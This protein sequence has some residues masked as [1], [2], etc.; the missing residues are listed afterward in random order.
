LSNNIQGINDYKRF[1]ESKLES[2]V[3]KKDFKHEKDALSTK[4]FEHLK[5]KEV[6]KA[7]NA[8][9]SWIIQVLSF[10]DPNYNTICKKV[11][12][13]YVQLNLLKLEP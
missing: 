9:K 11:D 5:K 12:W 2:E 7:T 1:V 3:F 4:Q 13:F 6:Q 10:D 8:L